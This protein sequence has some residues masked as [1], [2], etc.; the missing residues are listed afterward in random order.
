MPRGYFSEWA[1]VRRFAGP[2][3]AVEGRIDVEANPPCRNATGRGRGRG[4]SYR[5]RSGCARRAPAP[6]ARR[7]GCAATR[8]GRLPP[9]AP[10]PGRDGEV[11]AAGA[12]A[13]PVLR[14]GTPHVLENFVSVEKVSAVEEIDPPAEVVLIVILGG[15][16]RHNRLS[17]AATL[18][19]ATT[20]NQ[21]AALD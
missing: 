2:L 5:R 13:R 6:N 10:R 16:Q 21:N 8:G 20:E 19:L 17:F 1:C 11:L 12:A 18:H 15:K 3:A 14:Q 7:H 4:T 9:A